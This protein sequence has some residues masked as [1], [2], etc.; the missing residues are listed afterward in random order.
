[1]AT[2]EDTEQ[3]LKCQ[4]RMAAEE[5]RTG[6]LEQY[7]TGER[8]IFALITGLDHKFDTL[9]DKQDAMDGRLQRVEGRLDNQDKAQDKAAEARKPLVNTVFSVI[10][11]IVYGIVIALVTLWATTLANGGIK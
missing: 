6:R 9:G 11:Q 5:A 2:T 1:M 7:I 10:G 8:G 4:E 3:V